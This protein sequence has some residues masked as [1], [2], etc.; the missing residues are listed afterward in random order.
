MHRLNQCVLF[1]LLQTRTFSLDS[2]IQQRTHA[3]HYSSMNAIASSRLREQSTPPSTNSM[4]LAADWVGRCQMSNLVS[5]QDGLD[6]TGWTWMTQT[7]GPDLRTLK[8]TSWTSP[9]DTLSLRKLTEWAAVD[10]VG[11][12]NPNSMC[13]VCTACHGDL[14]SP[15]SRIF[16]TIWTHGRWRSV[17]L[18]LTWCLSASVLHSG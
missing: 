8:M 11:G 13:P 4:R 3:Q 5:L 14:W 17:W 9:W 18:V 16:W 2:M 6:R 10:M 7:C 12:N 1:M 15:N